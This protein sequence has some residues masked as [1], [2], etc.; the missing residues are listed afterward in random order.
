MKAEAAGGYRGRRTVIRDGVGD[1]DLGLIVRGQAKESGFL[2]NTQESHGKF[3]LCN[4][5]PGYCWRKGRGK[6]N[7]GSRCSCPGERRFW[8][9]LG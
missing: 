1:T 2:L 9:R 3:K 5:P 8:L 4:N 6:M 7:F